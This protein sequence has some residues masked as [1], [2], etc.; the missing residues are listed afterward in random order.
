MLSMLISCRH[1]TI[2]LES[3]ARLQ[4]VARGPL[5]QVEPSNKMLQ[6]ISSIEPIVFPWLVLPTLLVCVA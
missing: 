1:E 5:P 4:A 3:Y 6:A 2:P